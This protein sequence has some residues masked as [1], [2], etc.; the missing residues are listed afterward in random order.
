MTG[1]ELAIVEA[2]I[3]LMNV[4]NQENWERVLNIAYA[5]GQLEFNEMTEMSAKL[6]DLAQAVSEYKP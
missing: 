3:A 2:A 6:I 1:L 4:T 5:E